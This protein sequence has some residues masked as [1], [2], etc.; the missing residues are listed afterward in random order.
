MLSFDN[1][2][3]HFQEEQGWVRHSVKPVLSSH[4]LGMVGLWLITGS[5]DKGYYKKQYTKPLDA[6]ID[7]LVCRI[8]LK[9][10]IYSDFGRESRIKHYF[11]D[12]S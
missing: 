5:S 11:K 7:H 4:P 12:Y 2:G 8:F 10:T 1:Y 3:L 9:N 6:I